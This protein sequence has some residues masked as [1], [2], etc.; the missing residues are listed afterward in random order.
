MKTAYCT[1]C[2]RELIDEEV[3]EGEAH[4]GCGGYVKIL[5][6]DE[7]QFPTSMRYMIGF[8]LV[9]MA[10]LFLWLWLLEPDVTTWFSVLR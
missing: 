6:V 3:F 9:I 7:Q 10:A 4:E 5:H 1:L 8:V 2:H